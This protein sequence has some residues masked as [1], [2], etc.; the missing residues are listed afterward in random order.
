[1]HPL[2]EYVAKQLASHIG[3]RH[4]LVWYDVRQ[5]FTPF[6]A[7][8]RRGPK[9]AG[10]IVAVSIAGIRAQLAEFDGSFLELRARVEPYVS[11][12][13]PLDF[14]LYVPGQRL[15]AEE[16][17]LLELEQAGTRY[18]P[19][20]KSLARNALRRTYTDG[21][22]DELLAPE[23]VS[24][25]D[26]ARASQG[27]GGSEPPSR[28]KMIFHG[29]RPGG[30][31]PEW[32]MSAARD[33]E[34]LS[35]E[36]VR[37]L[38]KLIQSTCGLELPE[39]VALAKART[40]TLRYLLVNEFRAALGGTAPGCLEGVPRPRTQEQRT[41]ATE[42]V[43][44]LRERFP[45]EY[46]VAADQIEA[47]LGLPKAAIAVESL[48]SLETFRF[49][50]GAVLALCAEL[51]A[52]RRFDEALRLLD[53]YPASF[54]IRRDIPRSLQW[55][56]YRQLAELGSEVQAVHAAARKLTGG[57]DAWIA[58]YTD[59]RGWYRLDQ[60]H[61]RLE[62]LAGRVE[63]ELDERA[64]GIVRRAH[65][66][67]CQ[68]MSEGFTRALESAA[69]TVPRALHQTRV[70]SEVVTG[71]PKPVAYF[72]VDAMRYEMGVE[73]AQRLQPPDGA[74]AVE[75][76]I[77]AAVVALPSITPVGMAALLPG[78]SGS[79]AVIEQGG[80]LGV[81]IAGAFLP[82]WPSRR[83]F[84]AARI[85][86]LV[87]LTL[88]EVLG[89]SRSKLAKR[90]EGAQILIV[91]SQE[92]DHAGEAGFTYQAR[93]VMHTVIDN[94]A[95]AVRKLAALGIAEAVV[96]ADHGHL[97][98]SEREESM[99]IDAPGGE[100]V[101][102]HRRCWIGRGG[103]TPAGCVRVA[104]TALGYESDLDFVFP[105]G[106]G[107]FKSGGDLAFHHG[108][109]SLQEILVPVLTVRSGDGGVR[110]PAAESLH[111]TGLPSKITN[112]IFSI[113][114]ELKGD[115]LSVEQ[116]VLPLLLAEGRQVGRA[117][118][119]VDGAL[120]RDTGTVKLAP[121]KPVT[122]AF[123][124]DD[125]RVRTLRIV[126]QDPRSDAELYRSPADIPVELGT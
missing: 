63:E 37:E 14:I 124:L 49:A 9:E 64:L 105:R 23:S 126:I 80:K 97:F 74:P 108:A 45:T 90:V 20:L 72:L 51:I 25:E 47:E 56:A 19:Q 18:E 32:L 113:G 82:D 98:A 117:G 112:R 16:S 33:E 34:I 89:L 76:H 4:V 68:V 43:H 7:E 6:I 104:A 54:W 65:E 57:V 27:G 62:W 3:K 94:L 109:A 61:R 114:L 22:I 107:V 60:M 122:I 29:E 11:Q 53:R 95:R 85:P 10:A 71:R 84:L 12:D 15:K 44:I 121:R 55:Q 39:E 31:L 21:V 41:G 93:Q 106:C 120:D 59:A 2:H 96:A 91:R 35:K 115:L 26:L 118:M 66:D 101:D 79:F 78:A 103:K 48:A 110:V 119:V 58:A 5:E 50:E 69:W 46:V 111:V 24:Y 116:S 8:L 77:E 42:L 87:D 92:L 40:V 123:L 52:G 73:L 81:R 17:L 102:L 70:F 125:D 1:M 75:V 67:A 83:K 30:I 38:I 13:E 28:L 99:R 100:T 88:D 36:S 86:G